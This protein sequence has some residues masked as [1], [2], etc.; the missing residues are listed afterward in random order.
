MMSALWRQLVWTTKVHRSGPTLRERDCKRE[1]GFTLMEMVVAVFIVGVMIA[2]ITPHLLGAGKQ[3]TA[4]ACQQNVNAI[5]SALTEYAL[6]NGSLPTGDATTQMQALVDA[7][8]LA[9]MPGQPA[10]AVYTISDP[11][12]DHISVTCQVAQTGTN[13]VQ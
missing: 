7:Q 8:M 13:G 6:E 9:A 5:E 1:G 3:A 2:V 11:D 10:N 12:P 4:V